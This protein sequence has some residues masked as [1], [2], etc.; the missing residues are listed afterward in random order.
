MK[1]IIALLTLLAL[2]APAR[3]IVNPFIRA[4]VDFNKF[5]AVESLQSNAAWK[6]KLTGWSAGYFGEVGINLLGSH[7]L[8]I[9]AG[10]VN[11]KDSNSGIEKRQIPLLLNYR[12][13]T[14]LGPVS[15][16]LG[17]SA[18][19]MSDTM[20]WREDIGNA[21][22]SW[23]T[24]KS[25]NWVGVYGA[26]LGLGLKLGKN[27]GID[28]GVRALAVSAKQFQDGN[29]PNAENYTIGKS[30]I[31]VRPTVRLALSHYW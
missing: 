30:S 23:Q 24:F 3:A 29:L 22:S 31:Y 11:A 17:I 26:T 5:N 13:L 12:H 28:V 25:A 1:P 27:W 10:Y 16:I 8:G 14:N 6:D 18:G 4:G 20:K 15:L 21:T 9:E 7:T 19:M 2:T